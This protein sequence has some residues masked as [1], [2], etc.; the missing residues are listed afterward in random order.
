MLRLDK[1]DNDKHY[2]DLMVKTAT[3]TKQD[4]LRSEISLHENLIQP[5]AVQHT[6]HAHVGRPLANLGGQ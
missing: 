6:T 5:T 1:A 3:L 4:S 2:Q